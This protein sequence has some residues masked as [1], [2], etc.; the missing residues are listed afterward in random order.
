MERD[1]RFWNR[2]AGR[3]ARARIANA[4]AYEHKLALTREHLR[5]EMRLLELGCGTGATALHHAAR[6]QQVLGVD[7]SERMVDFA[8]ERAA[9]AGAGNLRFEVA[10]LESFDARG[11]TFDMV[12]ALNLLHL[13]ADLDLALARIHALTRPAGLFVSST[14]CLADGYAFMRYLGPPGR[15]LGLL[16]RILVFSEEEYA[17]ALERAGFRIESRYQPED[18]KR[19]AVFMIARKQ[20][21]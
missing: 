1:S 19:A 15:V 17:A 4:A 14:A 11:D 12:L 16:P 9:R 8:R 20:L 5:P 13:V 6:V 10:S 21:R 2:I 18:Q 3:Y 7:F